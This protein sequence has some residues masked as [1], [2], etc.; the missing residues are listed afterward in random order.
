MVHMKTKCPKLGYGDEDVKKT[1]AIKQ[2]VVKTLV[3]KVETTRTMMR[4]LEVKTKKFDKN[5]SEKKT[6][7]MIRKFSGDPYDSPPRIYKSN[8]MIYKMV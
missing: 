6:S 8:S 4:I 3:E 7:D 2:F 1:V 5:L